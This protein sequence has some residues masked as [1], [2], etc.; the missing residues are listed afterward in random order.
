MGERLRIGIPFV[1]IL[2]GACDFQERASTKH[3]PPS[4]SVV[5]QSVLVSV[6]STGAQADGPTYNASISE[7]GSAVAY[8]AVASNLAPFPDGTPPGA[9]TATHVYVHDRVSGVTD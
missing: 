5:D 4:R 2:F 9:M 6:S 3:R 1:A 8:V 7:D